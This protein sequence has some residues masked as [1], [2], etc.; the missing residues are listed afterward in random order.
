MNAEVLN[1]SLVEVA[2]AIRRKKLSAVEVTR[3]CLEHAARVQPRLNCF[4]SIEAD[5]A[6]RAARKADQALKRLRKVGPLHGVP[7]AHKDMYYRAGKISTCGSKILRDYR[8]RVTATVIERLEAAG[9]IWMGGLNM[10]EFAANPTGH[11]DHWGHCRNP[12]NPA[13]MTG[14]SSSGSGSA[15]AARACYGALGSDTGGSVRLPAA[16]CGVV[17]LK[18]THGLISRYGIMPRS[19]SQD[20]VGPLTR[21]VRDCALMTR[22]VAGADPR[23][24]TCVDEP[25]P[26]YERAL[27]GRIRGIKIG[28]PANHYYDG[29]TEDVRRRM[30]ESLAVFKSLGARIVEIKVPDPQEIF[31]LSATVSQSEAA[32][33]HGTW[34]RTRPQDYSLY[35]LS[36]MEAGFHIPAATYAQALNLRVHLLEEF[37]RAVYTKVDLL[38]APVMVMPPPTIA[39]TEPRAS[40]DV[41]EIVA[42]IT[43]NTRPTNYLGLPALSVPAGFSSGG[44]PIAFQLMGRPFAEALIF[45]AAH[46][47][48]QETD[49]HTRA[50]QL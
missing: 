39:G 33:I 7:L 45:R 19:W 50:P 47:Y 8:P 14:G 29:A 30:D 11:N 24:P 2:A 9:A 38:H 20:T 16:A 23:D 15:V 22:V 5:A 49:W 25:A 36:R 26:D 17:G 28:V 31:L 4:I 41:T 46:L 48:Q 43:R 3:A 12:W 6:L 35:V 42:R 40:G 10:S 27:A 18:P 13:H 32:T 1:L 21:T 37:M 44:L 34:I